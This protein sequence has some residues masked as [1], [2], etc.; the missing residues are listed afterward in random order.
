MSYLCPQ[1]RFLAELFAATAVAGSTKSR[2][3]LLLWDC[4]MLSVLWIAKKIVGNDTAKVADYEVIAREG[5]SKQATAR[6]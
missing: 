1:W 3:V 4:L 2:A 6:T 5:L